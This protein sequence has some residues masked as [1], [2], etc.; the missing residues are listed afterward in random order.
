VSGL[1]I[2]GR[3]PRATSA[4]VVPRVGRGVLWALVLVLLVRGLADVFA[5]YGRVAAVRVE[6]PAAPLWPDD[7]ARAFGAAFA[8]T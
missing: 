3:A 1:T 5:G 2:R 8:R 7:E 4:D 6:R